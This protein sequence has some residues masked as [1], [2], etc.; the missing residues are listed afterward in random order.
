MPMGT[1]AA[2]ATLIS[3][4]VAATGTGLQLSG[5]LTPD[6]PRPTPPSTAATP[7]TANQNLQQKQLIANQNPNSQA[8]GGGSFSPGYDAEFA[9]SQTGL[10]GDPQA[11][12]NAQAVMASLKQNEGFAAPGQTGFTPP[13]SGS[14]SGGGGGAGILDLLKN[15]PQPGA[16]GVPGGA[17]FVSQQM[18][19]EAFKGLGG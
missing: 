18:N 17:D 19:S 9:L 16:P 13:N 8:A 11:Q 4:A 15:M 12:A 10:S 14:T 7:L 6:S 5:A 3:S 2:I 1:L